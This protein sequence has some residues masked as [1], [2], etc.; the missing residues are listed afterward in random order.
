MKLWVLTDFFKNW[1]TYDY[2]VYAGKGIPVSK[3]GLV[4]DVVMK[5]SKSL[6]EQAYRI[7]IVVCSYLEIFMQ[8]VVYALLFQTGK[9]YL[10]SL[11][12]LEFLPQV[13]EYNFAGKEKVTCYFF[14]G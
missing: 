5:L 14:S 3:F 9:K 2:E 11:R 8:K 12:M 1:C 4:Y 10:L 6:L 7:F 13:Q